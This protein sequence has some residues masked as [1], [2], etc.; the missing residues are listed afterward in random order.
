M[1]NAVTSFY[2][3]T[4]HIRSWVAYPTGGQTQAPELH[5]VVAWT[6]REQNE[7]HQ[8]WDTHGVQHCA[9]HCSFPPRRVPRIIAVK[10]SRRIQRCGSIRLRSALEHFQCFERESKVAHV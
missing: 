8:A 4:T 3:Q 6:T 7:R 2:A 9:C 5:G 10:I 1:H